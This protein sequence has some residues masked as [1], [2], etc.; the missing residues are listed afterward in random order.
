MPVVRLGGLEF[1]VTP[2]LQWLLLP[3][4][5]LWLARRA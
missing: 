2:M 1:G 3:P 4:L 5:A